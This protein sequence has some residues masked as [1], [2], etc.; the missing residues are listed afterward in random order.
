MNIREACKILGVTEQDD[1]RTIKWQFRKKISEHHP[2]V[3]GDDLPEHLRQA[4]RINE[5]YAM[6]CK[7]R[8]D[9]DNDR[10]V[11]DD[12]WLGEVDEGAFAPRNVYVSFYGTMAYGDDGCNDAEARKHYY[13]VAKGRY[14]WDPDLEDFD[15]L[16]LSLN[17]LT[18]E[19]ME[20]IERKNGIYGSMDI[21]E[22]GFKYQKSL[23]HCL[24]SQYIHPLY[25]LKRQSEP[26]SMDKQGQEIYA[27]NA[28]LGTRGTSNIFIAMEGL[29]QGELLYPASITDNRLMVV[30][31]E[32]QKLGHLSLEEDQLYYIVIPILKKHMAQVKLV[33][34]DVYIVKNTR[35]YRAKVNVK[36][37]LK[38]KNDLKKEDAETG[39]LNIAIGELLN[40][41]DEELKDI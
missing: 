21:G 20:Q 9:K 12:E 37:Y 24:A 35:P 29:R 3:V 34:Q 41:Y 36:L 17:H 10:D 18:M 13:T 33:V 7:G 39:S 27:F 31:K 11:T 40:K 30:N 32:G 23:F 6:L 15:M 16:L 25:S 2:D 14:I 26:I 22:Q 19:L 1:K 28:F 38:M 4:Q 5:A 8:N